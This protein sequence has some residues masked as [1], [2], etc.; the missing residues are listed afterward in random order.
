MIIETVAQLRALYPA[1]SE[2]VVK[3]ELAALDGHCQRFIALSPFVV[4]GSGSAQ[5]MDAS[6]RGGTPG[7]VRVL[8][9]NTLLIPDV[10]GNNRLDTLQNIIASGQ[11]G[12]LF[13]IPGVEETLRVN[14]AARLSTRA[15]SLAHFADEKR[16]PKLVIE[17]SVAAAFLHCPK[18]LMRAR[19]WHPAAQVERAVMPPLAEMINEQTGIVLPVPSLEEARANYAKD[20]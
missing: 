6:P 16:P 18:A 2:R 13:L 11:V 10:A 4:I 3:K 1:P 5:A 7:F 14:G 17:V 9:E 8:D 19:L 20:L 12:L 15:A